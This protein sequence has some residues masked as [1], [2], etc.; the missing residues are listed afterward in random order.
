[1]LKFFLED[2]PDEM[3]EVL[4]ADRGEVGALP[5]GID[6]SMLSTNR[7]SSRLMRISG[8]TAAMLWSFELV[9]ST[10]SII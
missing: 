2:F 10:V 3:L 5:K 4:P 8:G 1:V 6:T 9:H 7:A